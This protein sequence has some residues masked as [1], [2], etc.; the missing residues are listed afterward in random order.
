MAATNPPLNLP[1]RIFVIS[2]L[3]LAENIPLITKR[4]EAS[5]FVRRQNDLLPLSG[6]SLKQAVLEVPANS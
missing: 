2:D 6:R 3:H 1:H 4:V 5:E